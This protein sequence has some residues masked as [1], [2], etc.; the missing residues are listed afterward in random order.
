MDIAELRDEVA[1]LRIDAVH[2]DE[3]I[4]RLEVMVAE[5]ERKQNP[6]GGKLRG[7]AA[8]LQ[9]EVDD[10]A[11]QLAVRDKKI[12]ALEAALH[13]P[14]TAAV[15]AASPDLAARIA[16]LDLKLISLEAAVSERDQQ[17]VVLKRELSDAAAAA[18]E[19]PM[20]LRQPPAAARSP[21]VQAARHA[22]ADLPS[23]AAS[24]CYDQQPASNARS[25]SGMRGAQPQD[26]Q[27]EALYAEIAS[28]RAKVD[29][30]LQGRAALQELVTEQQVKIRQLRN[31]GDTSATAPDG[32]VTGASQ[33][34]MTQST[35]PTTHTQRKRVPPADCA[36]EVERVGVV[37]P[38]RPKSAP[39]TPFE[40]LSRNILASVSAGKASTPKQ[41]RQAV[42]R[43]SDSSGD[44]A[45][46]AIERLLRDKRISSVNRT[47]RL[48]KFIQI[49]PQNLHAALLAMPDDMPA[50]DFV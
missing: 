1:T 24:A 16:Q 20:R 48:L 3:T 7:R 8:A 5:L 10:L 9:A 13:I 15:D 38:K 28:L 29:R 30:L 23:K 40:L 37:V 39:V 33:P 4:R 36:D 42:V 26:G 14:A 31:G 49:S 50:I 34:L 41:S 25:R 18:S 44:S 35:A 22:T 17:I 46:E 6:E 21:S 43:Q 47:K 2:K 27:G 32:D 45:T 11:A 19:R 12:D